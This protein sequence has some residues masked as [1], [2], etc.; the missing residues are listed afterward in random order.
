MLGCVDTGLSESGQT[1]CGRTEDWR[2]RLWL[3]CMASQSHHYPCYGSIF[4]GFTGDIGMASGMPSDLSWLAH[5]VQGDHSN[6]WLDMALLQPQLPWKSLCESWES[7]HG[8]IPHDSG[9]KLVTCLSAL[10]YSN[11]SIQHFGPY[12][13]ICSLPCTLCPRHPVQWWI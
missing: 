3:P 10:F 9:C 12:L 1:V 7:I 13:V 5:L 11:T 6:R 8:P 4:A 2:R